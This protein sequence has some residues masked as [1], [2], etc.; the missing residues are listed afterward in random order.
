M[1]AFI[2]SLNWEQKG[3]DSS[4]LVDERHPFNVIFHSIKLI[5]EEFDSLLNEQRQLNES[6]IKEIVTRKKA[7]KAL[8][9]S[10]DKLEQSTISLKESNIALKV[11]LK[12]R[13]EDK[14]EIEEKILHNVEKLI[15]PYLEKLKSQKYEIEKNTYL[16]IIES[17]LKEIVSPFSHS[18]SDNL[19]KLTP[20][21]IQVADM[22]RQ[23]KTTKDIA[24]LLRLSP[25][26]VA[27][28]RQRIRRKLALTNKKMNLQTNLQNIYSN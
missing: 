10:Y 4:F 19:L 15:I 22:I 20:T 26:T 3:V 28:H 23:G 14:K 27:T 16:E 1:L 24:E 8:K 17:N 11:L 2:A 7:E 13:E 5:K 9:E 6:L 12:Q 21:E 25:T 18:L